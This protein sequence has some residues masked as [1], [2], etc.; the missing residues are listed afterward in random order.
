MQRVDEWRPTKYEEH[1]GRLR[2]S[3]DLA[4]VGAG[5]RL[6]ADRVTDFYS[7]VVP[8]HAH[9][10]LLDLGC[11]KA[12]MYG[13]YRRFVDDA[14]LVDWADSVHA[15]PHLDLVHDLNRP[16]S[17]FGDDSFGTVVLS[18]VLEHIREPGGLLAEISR[19]LEPGGVLLAN[20]PFLYGLHEVPHDFYRYTRYALEHLNSQAGLEMVQLKPLG[21]FPEVLTDLVAKA[22]SQ[23]PFVGPRLALALQA[24]T[25]SLTRRGPGRRASDSTM[26]RLPIGY[27]WVARKPA[28]G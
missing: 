3:R 17:D 15:N 16:L 20:V 23:V 19:V 2:A 1:N 21:G 25:A 6:L 10:R 27:G 22:L 4:E 24:V 5:S 13:F 26:D 28:A 9:G 7:D 11:G 18:D 8:R 12:P 14:T